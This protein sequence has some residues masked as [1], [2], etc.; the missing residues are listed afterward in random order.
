MP[1][2]H[3]THHILSKHT[4]GSNH[5]DN[6]VRMEI[7]DHRNLHDFFGHRHP[8]EQIGKI[9]DVS[10]SVWIP[11]RIEAI[12]ALIQSFGGELYKRHCLR[13]PGAKYKKS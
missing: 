7:K 2:T 4:F 6:R 12:D 3:N 10:E 9:L 5:P 13:E 11:D 1:I 8:A